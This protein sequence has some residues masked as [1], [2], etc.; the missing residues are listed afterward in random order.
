MVCSLRIAIWNANGAA[1][2]NNEIHTFL[3]VNN[4]DILMIS[5]THFAN[6]NYFKIHNYSMYHTPHPSDRARGGVAIIIRNSIKH[7]EEVKYQEEHIQATTIVIKEWMGQLALAAV[8]CSL[9]CNIKI[10]QFKHFFSTLS[11]RFIAGGDYNA[12]HCFWGSRIQNH[13]GKQPYN[14]IQ[15]SRLSFLSSGEPTYWLKQKTPDL[16]DFC[17][18]KGLPNNLAIV[19][20][21][22]DLTSDHSPIIINLFTKAVTKTCHPV[23]CN[24]KTDWN[25]FR[26]M[27]KESLHFNISL[28]TPDEIDEAVEFLNKHIQ[29]VTWQN[30]PEHT[31]IEGQEY[32][33]PTIREKNIIRGDLERGG[34]R[35]EHQVI[36]PNIIEL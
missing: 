30:T 12:K 26:E 14:V 3:T 5:E 25:S 11:N 2:H 28:K 31:V 10:Q 1:K 7:Y 22:F 24:N 19:K 20:S 13:R 16:L 35:L 29:E 36:K 8:Y 17:V 9:N 23:L 34:L 21:C 4:I 33:P 27:L 18:T 32:C 6:K 15:S